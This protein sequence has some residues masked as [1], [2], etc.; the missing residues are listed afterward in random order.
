MES[1][2]KSAV[3]NDEDEDEKQKWMYSLKELG[4]W[5]SVHGIQ[6]L[7]IRPYGDGFRVVMFGDGRAPSAVAHAPTLAQAVDN[8]ASRFECDFENETT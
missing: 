1:E 6:R 3:M 7:M 5:I 8:A 2:G 4:N